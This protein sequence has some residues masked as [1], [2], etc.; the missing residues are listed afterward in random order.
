[1]VDPALQGLLDAVSDEEAERRLD[2]LIEER[3][4]PLVRT[5]VARK[6]SAS[7]SKQVFRPEDLQDV[8]GDTILALLTKLQSLRNRPVADAIVSLDDYAAAVTYRVCAHHLRRRYPERA[9]IKD[10]LRY[11]LGRD[12]RFA[13]WEVAGYGLH[14]G[15]SS[16]RGR[17]ADRAGTDRLAEIERDPARW[18]A[19]WKPPAF[20]ERADPAPILEDV[21]KVSAGPLELD[22]LVNLVAA[23]WQVDRVARMDI[24]DRLDRLADE[25]PDPEVTIDRHRF[26]ERVWTEI[27]QLPLRQRHALLLNLRDSQGAGL[28]WTFPVTGVASLRAIASVLEMPVDDFAALWSQLPLDDAALAARLECTRQQVINLRMSARKRLNNRLRDADARADA[29]TGVANLRAVSVSMGSDT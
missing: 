28:L 19:S 24:G 8:A 20:V 17:E 16:W 4:A 5:I 1:M 18:P 27:Q 2:A 9:R 22:R 29:V 11:V 6:L 12:R 26:A 10:R 14:A 25:N 21:F 13:L 3:L 15:L 23:I 7:G